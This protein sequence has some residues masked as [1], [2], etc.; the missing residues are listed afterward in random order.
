M[1]V[2]A[3]A[4]TE[5]QKTIGSKSYRAAVVVVYI[6]AER[7]D[8]ATGERIDEVRIVATNLP[9]VDHIFVDLGGIVRR[10]VSGCRS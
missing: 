3:I 7:N 6:F 1:R 9:L 2:S 8:L 4:Q 10:D 5:I